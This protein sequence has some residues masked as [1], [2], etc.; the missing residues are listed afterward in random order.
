MCDRYSDDPS[1]SLLAR[2]QYEREVRYLRQEKDAT[3]DEEMLKL[4]R[5]VV[6][7]NV[8]RLRECPNQW[9]LSLA[10]HARDELVTLC[11]PMILGIA[12][13]VARRVPGAS[14]E[15]LDLVSE[16]NLGLLRLL[17]EKLPEDVSLPVF[18]ALASKY[19]SGSMMNA[20]RRCGQLGEHSTQVVR[21]V[22]ELSQVQGRFLSQQGREP[23]YQEMAC[24]MGVRVERVCELIE[25]RGLHRQESIERSL[26]GYGEDDQNCVALFG[27]SI[28]DDRACQQEREEVLSRAMGEALTDHQRR[29][30]CLRY[31]LGGLKHSCLEAARVTG[32]AS[33]GSS[34]AVWV[35]EQ[36]ALE[37]LRQVFEGG[38]VTSEQVE[39]WSR[40]QR[41]EGC[42]TVAETARLLG[43][44]VP[45]VHRWLSQGRLVGE[46]LEDIQVG[47]RRGAWL[48]P[49]EAVDALVVERQAVA[50]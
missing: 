6:R 14:L 4:L 39:R 10:K 22:N 50:V 41:R 18:Y 8:E 3:S 46:Y 33:D 26:E 38:E 48:L 25:A 11:Q 27:Q 37:R 23:S 32:H 13:K 24:E 7:G 5:R 36:A 47:N 31:G 16:G 9:V 20:L 35:C 34:G 2:D 1:I 49:K 29:V 42:Y 17:D 43:I 30:V 21:Q 12:Y 28:E 45:T 44:S 40:R 15:V 19:V